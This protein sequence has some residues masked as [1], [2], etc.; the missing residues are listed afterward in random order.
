[1]SREFQKHPGI[2][3]TTNGG[4]ILSEHPQ[5]FPK[6]LPTNIPRPP[7][8]KISSDTI[9]VQK[10]GPVR[11]KVPARGLKWKR[12]RAYF[13]GRDSDSSDSSADSDTECDSSSQISHSTFSVDATRKLIARKKKASKKSRGITHTQGELR[14]PPG[15]T[16]DTAAVQNVTNSL[17]HSSSRDS[18]RPSTSVSSTNR[19]PSS[20]PPEAL[21]SRIYL[22]KSKIKLYGS[23]ETCVTQ[24]DEELHDRK[25]RAT[26]TKRTWV[27]HV[28][29]VVVEEERWEKK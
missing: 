9:K 7:S 2:P 27:T 22:P 8:P 15:A 14:S 25:G 23:D 5:P 12:G 19:R 11:W 13:W 24:T 26:G 18:S 20:S 6:H 28:R 17:R 21:K 16:S 10:W 1:M 3:P 29:K 4:L